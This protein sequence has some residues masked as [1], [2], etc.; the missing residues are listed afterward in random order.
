MMCC[1]KKLDGNNFIKQIQ[2]WCVDNSIVP[3]S[4]LVE[5][6]IE[7]HLSSSNLAINEKDE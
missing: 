1:I 4:T 7:K 3:T 6:L 5:R 2:Q